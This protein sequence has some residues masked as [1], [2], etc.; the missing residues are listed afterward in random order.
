MRT[1]HFSAADIVVSDLR[2]E[3]TDACSLV[4]LVTTYAHVLPSGTFDRR[5]GYRWL[6]AGIILQVSHSDALPSFALRTLYTLYNLDGRG[7]VR[8][9]MF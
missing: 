7:H 6:S 8:L 5:T 3:R 4:L 9:R 1:V 2:G